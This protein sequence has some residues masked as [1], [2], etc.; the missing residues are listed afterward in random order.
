MCKNAWNIMM[1]GRF[2]AYDY[3]FME[4][5]GALLRFMT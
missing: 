3:A 5:L 4:E 1:L 2:M